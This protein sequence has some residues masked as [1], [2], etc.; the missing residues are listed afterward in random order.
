MTSSPGLSPNAASN[1]SRKST[2][3]PSTSK[4]VERVAAAPST[5]D[6]CLCRRV[7]GRRRRRERRRRRGRRGRTC[8]GACF[9]RGATWPLRPSAPITLTS[10]SQTPPLSM[11]G[12]TVGRVG[13]NIAEVKK[14]VGITGNWILDVNF[15]NSV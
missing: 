11:T 4:R 2:P 15:V 7:P 5:A 6:L 14:S 3:S 9:I 13:A 1:T 12:C 8:G 10:H